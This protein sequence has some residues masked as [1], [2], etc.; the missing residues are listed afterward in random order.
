MFSYLR[1][2]NVYNTRYKIFILPIF[3]LFINESMLGTSVQEKGRVIDQ[4]IM[5]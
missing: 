3:F 4:F 2:V 1:Q 5:T